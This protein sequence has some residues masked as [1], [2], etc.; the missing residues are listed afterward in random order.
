MFHFRLN[1]CLFILVAGLFFFGFFPSDGMSM[2]EVILGQDM[3]FTIGNIDDHSGDADSDGTDAYANALADY[4]SSSVSQAKAGVAYEIMGSENGENSYLAHLTLEF[5]Y[6]ITVDYS[7]GGMVEA[8]VNASHP[9]E[10]FGDHVLFFDP[11]NYQSGERVV[12]TTTEPI[13]LSAQE[14]RTS[15][16][17]VF[18]RAYI[19]EQEYYAA[20]ALAYAS[21][22]LKSL[23]IHFLPPPEPIFIYEPAIPKLEDD[24]LFDASDSI[25]PEGN[26]CS[27]SWDIDGVPAGLGETLHATF[28][29]VGTYRV[30]LTVKE[31][32]YGQERQY[33]KDLT[34]RPLPFSIP[35]HWPFTTII[36]NG[37]PRPVISGPVLFKLFNY[38]SATANLDI[39]DVFWTGNSAGIFAIDLDTCTGESIEPGLVSSGAIVVRLDNIGKE[40]NATLNVGYN[41]LTGAAFLIPISHKIFSLDSEEEYE[42]I[43]QMCKDLKDAML[44]GI[45]DAGKIVFP[46][47]E[48][49]YESLLGKDFF[50]KEGKKDDIISKFDG[51]HFQDAVNIINNIPGIGCINIPLPT[52]LRM[53]LEQTQSSDEERITL[54][55]FL[56][57][58]GN[59]RW[60]TVADT[61]DYD[62][63]GT[64]ID[65]FKFIFFQTDGNTANGYSIVYSKDTDQFLEIKPLFGSTNIMDMTPYKTDYD[66]DMDVDGKNLSNFA[67]K[68]DLDDVSADLNSDG[69]VNA[70]D[71][72]VF[73]LEFGD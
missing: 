50:F 59:T 31:L 46:D 9:F 16:I 3:E 69:I 18:A 6:S 43:E 41:S 17:Y 14:K 12:L 28:H 23:K 51:I 67:A 34:F 40:A 44:A 60:F 58:D 42:R 73:A 20:T 15:T 39:S 10:A 61:I 70:A 53:T 32:D 57:T 29:D 2:E 27:Y 36:I 54:V 55:D 33:Y 49:D 11:G 13:V 68:Y 64:V 35:T 21:A 24:I 19:Y 52:A 47:T 56:Q 38:S 26:T 22:N 30:R 4:F 37:Q 65:A 45:V 71:L 72:A 1:V 7:G 5:D 25:C 48:F 8:Q 63:G 62:M 66:I